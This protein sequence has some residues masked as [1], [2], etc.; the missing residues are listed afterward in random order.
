MRTFVK[1]P[2]GWKYESYRH[3]LAAHGVQ[4]GNMRHF[5]HKGV[6]TSHNV[7]AMRFNPSEIRKIGEGSDRLAFDIGKDKVLKVAKN[8]RGLAQNAVEGKEA[9]LTPKVVERGEDYVVVKS[10]TDANRQKV[11]EK[12]R[13]LRKFDSKDFDERNPELV[14]EL[15]RL[16][17][18]ELLDKQHVAWG[19]VVK[20]SSWTIHDGKLLLV[21]AGALTTDSTV[22]HKLFNRR[23]PSDVRKWREVIREREKVVEE[24]S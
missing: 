1:S 15:K 2:V 5:A 4:T 17:I 8:P 14:A 9:P 6:K 3:S 16:G 7:A 18:D 20:P 19:D 22:K 10:A 21:D 12:I 13:V 11:W 23:H 24:K